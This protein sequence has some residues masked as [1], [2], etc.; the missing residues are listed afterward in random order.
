MG[1]IVSI[2]ETHKVGHL[3]T[4]PGNLH[5]SI[6]DKDGLYFDRHN[7]RTN[8]GKC[9]TNTNIFV[10]SHQQKEN[11]AA[12]CHSFYYQRS[13]CG[14]SMS[15][16]SHGEKLVNIFRNRFLLTELTLLGYTGYIMKWRLDMNYRSSR[17]YILLSLETLSFP[18]RTYFCRCACSQAPHWIRCHQ[19]CSLRATV[20]KCSTAYTE[21]LLRLRRQISISMKMTA[22]SPSH[23]SR[24]HCLSLKLLPD[25]QIKQLCKTWVILS[26]IRLYL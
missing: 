25:F 19:Q 22:A 8:G 17:K 3:V 23:R 21:R 13:I 15:R 2:C 14:L 5:T 4:L 6:N 24:P 9:Q 16:L 10:P 20:I 26:L 18:H 11:I 7:R 12:F 1:D